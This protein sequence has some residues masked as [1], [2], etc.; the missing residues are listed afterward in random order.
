MHGGYREDERARLEYFVVGQ[1]FMQF[2]RYLPNI[3]KQGFGSKR[4]QYSYGMYKP[5]ETYKDYKKQELAIAASAA[6]KAEKE[7]QIVEWHGRIQEGK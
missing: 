6:P 7:A 4:R 1:L 5:I 3:L 2:K